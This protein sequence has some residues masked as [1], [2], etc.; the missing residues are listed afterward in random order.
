MP[1]GDVDLELV[2]SVDQVNAFMRWLS[3]SRE[4]LAFDSE[5]QGLDPEHDKV[6]LV[7]FGDMNAGW[8]IPW[9]GWGGVA[10]EVFKKYEGEFVGHN[11]K[12]DTRMLEYWGKTRLPRERIHC[13]RIMA[14]LLN[15][16][17]STA[18][19]PNAARLVDSR[20]AHAS[21]ALDEAMDKQ[22]WT[23]ATVPIDFQLYWIYGALDTVL[24]AHLYN[25]FKP[26]IDAQYKAVYDLEQTVQF[27]LADM[28]SHGCR[29]DLEYTKN[30]A[31]ELTIFGENVEAWCNETY[32]VSPGSNQE[33]CKRLLELGVEL[34]HRTPT[35]QFKFDEDVINEI[36]GGE[37]TAIN[38]ATLNEGQ[39]LAYKI[40]M[41]RKAEK[42]R[43]TYLENFLEFVDPSGFAHPRINQ[44]GAVTGRMSME[45]PALQTLPRGRVVRDC[46][47]P[48]EGNTLFSADFDAVEMRILAHFAQD[49]NL[50]DA[51]NS[52]DIHLAMAKL[53]Y[54]DDTIT[55]KDPR[56]QVT[57]SVNF[58]RIYGAGLEK[59]ALT[60]GVT[61]AEMGAFS[62]MYNTEFPGVKAYQN[63]VSATARERKRDEGIA[64]VKTPIGRL[65]TNGDDRDYA[66]ANYLIQGMAGDVFKEA[67]VRLDE[68]GVAKYA[69]LPVHDEV[70]FDVPLADADEVKATIVEA[71]YDSRW[72]VPLTVGI[73]GPLSRWGEK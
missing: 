4:I 15:P 47:I 26:K 64:Y 13:T 5:T 7:Q 18:L 51:I 17:G 53:V 24:T 50:I 40:L 31:R 54:H 63:R 46:F 6:R 59:Q 12:F 8:A 37:Y 14:H 71:M 39:T 2:D 41:R 69:I 36:I 29:V 72:T 62:N 73:E 28:E 25:Q 65:E 68:A 61:Q 45:R 1:L 44:L 20:A 34:P 9:E 16:T 52:G 23:W 57:K 3:E 22:K 10:M 70:I 27:I 67:L 56:R 19:K 30:K 32:K 49:Q 35:G 58:A 48:S 60:A 11:A 55:K 21:A 42:I 33:V 38:P 43:N 66:L